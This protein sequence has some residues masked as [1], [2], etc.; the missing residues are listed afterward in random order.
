MDKG[1]NLKCNKLGQKKSF[2]HSLIHLTDFLWLSGQH[3]ESV[4]QASTLLTKATKTKGKGEQ[5]LKKKVTHVFSKEGAVISLLTF[6]V[7]L[8]ITLHFVNVGLRVRAKRK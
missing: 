3:E 4:S 1:S 2:F 7:L 5:T 8:F 6:G